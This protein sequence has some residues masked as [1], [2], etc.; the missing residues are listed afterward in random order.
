MEDIVD[1]EELVV[2]EIDTELGAE[3]VVDLDEE[4]L[5]L[6]VDIVELERIS[7]DISLLHT[8]NIRCVE[9]DIINT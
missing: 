4:K 9:I 1:M 8:K 7:V 6:D 3:T 5:E 2:V